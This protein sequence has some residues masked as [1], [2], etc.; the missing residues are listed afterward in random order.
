MENQQQVDA[1]KVI[2]SLLRQMSEYIQK[3][4]VLEALLAQ[5]ESGEGENQ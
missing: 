5:K 4:A 2:E 3:V 1:N